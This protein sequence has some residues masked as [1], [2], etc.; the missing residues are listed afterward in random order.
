MENSVIIV[1]AFVAYFVLVLALGLY[2][3]RDIST[4]ED[5]SVA[6]RNVSFWPLVGTVVGT[7]IGG[8]TLIAVTA[9]AYETGL[10]AAV[11]FLSAY[12]FI[13][14]WALL[15]VRYINRIRQFTLPDFFA[16]RFG[17]R[18]RVP[19][20]IFT[21]SRSIILTGMQI[22]AMGGVMSVVIGW[23]LELSMVVSTVVT[24]VYCLMG[25][26]R[27]VIVT[28]GLQT[29]LQTL[30]P[31]VLLVLLFAQVGTAPITAPSVPDTWSISATG[32]GVFFGLVAASGPY[33]FIYQPMWQRTYAAKDE[34]TAYRG[35]TIGTILSFFS[36]VLPIL[37]G[38]LARD[39]VP[40]NVD[41][42][43]A[44]PHLYLQE[45]P[46]WAGALF[47]VSLVGSIMSVLD[48]MV[49]DATANFVRDIYQKRMGVVDEVKL[50]RAGRVCTVV[51]C[52]V[53]LAMAFTITDLGQL[54][55]LGNALATGGLFVVAVAAWASRRATA[56]G[57][58]SAIVLGGG[59]TVAVAAASWLL[60]GDPAVGFFG[61]TPVYA[62]FIVGALALIVGSLISSPAP[63]EDPDSTLWSQQL[64]RRRAK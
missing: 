33:Y 1:V 31:V 18:V 64:A 54:F 32:W 36:L 21:M 63:E 26:M 58:W 38:V 24:V 42:A 14:I 57:A 59:A 23:P 4:Q 41:P 61:I 40:G 15:F 17:E 19:S 28:D 9:G 12:F 43:Q 20:A 30:G 5:F 51:V 56:T 11:P 47:A 13:M 29:V 49:L 46:T 55:V 52:A 2:H 25:G 10:S 34:D 35:M 6:G 3:K 48:S 37:I 53:G 39:V 22:L 50:V 8:G 27:S 60:R 45:M 16:L 7:N 62:A 44:L